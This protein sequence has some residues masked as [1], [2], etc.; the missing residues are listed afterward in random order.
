MQNRITLMR[1]K[2]SEKSIIEYQER[3]RVQAIL[4]IIVLLQLYNEAPFCK[5]NYLFYPTH[6]THSWKKAQKMMSRG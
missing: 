2:H 4:P 6:Y 3:V 5:M 1:N